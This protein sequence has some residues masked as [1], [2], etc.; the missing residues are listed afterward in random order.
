MKSKIINTLYYNMPYILSSEN[1][2]SKRTAN[3][4]FFENEN[5]KLQ[6]HIFKF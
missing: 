6:K 1:E 3:I 5:Y 2:D 4:I